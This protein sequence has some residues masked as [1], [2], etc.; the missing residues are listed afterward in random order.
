MMKRPRKVF[1]IES[2]PSPQTIRPVQFL[3]ATWGIMRG[4]ALFKR[5]LSNMLIYTQF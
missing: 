3:S 1:G 4:V 5:L 2:I